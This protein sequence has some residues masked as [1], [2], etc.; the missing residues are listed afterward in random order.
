MKALLR[1][2]SWW[3]C[4]G[5]ASACLGGATGCDTVALVSFQEREFSGVESPGFTSTSGSCNA[6][7]NGEATL[8][9]VLLAD[10]QTPIQPGQVVSN[11]T[12]DA[13]TADQVEFSDSALFEL[14]DVPCSAGECRLAEMTCSTAPGIAEEAGVNRCLRDTS[15]ALAGPIQ[16]ESDTTKAQLFGVMYENAGSLEGWLPADVGDKY[17]D[18]DGDGTA[19]GQQDPGVVRARASD[20]EG[21]RKAALTI[22]GTNWVTAMQNAL[23]ENRTTQ[24]GLWE[25]SGQSTQE[26]I[27]LVSKVHPSE[28]VW[29]AGAGIVESARESTNFS[30]VSGTRANVYQAILHVLD[31]AY[32]PSEFTGHEKTLV[33]FVDGPDDLRLPQF[34]PQAVIQRATDL[35]VRIFIVHLDAAQEPTTQGGTPVHRDDPE[36][37][38][39]RVD[40]QPIQEPCD[41]G[42]SCKNFEE[43]RVPVGYSSTPGGAIEIDPMG[44]TYC[45]P[46]RDDNGRIGPIE[47]YS[48]IA[49][50]TDGGYIYVKDAQGLRPR[51]DWLPFTMDGL[52]KADVV[53]DDLAN[54][55]VPSDE[56]YKLQTSMRVTLGGITRSVD[57]SQRGEAA[58][59]DDA[60]D[61]RSVIFN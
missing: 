60:A 44:Q 25:F 15:V 1:G 20:A 11:Q 61:T 51:M 19:E 5:I 49:C 24:F 46:T 55:T 31:T 43:C 52:W 45:M 27:S 16:F 23:R 42:S 12:V 59:T 33:V 37:W 3:L 14:P 29:A 17:P 39:N 2:R 7:E 58:P 32:A 40:G 38:S 13:L 28:Q 41:D 35:A 9:F 4:A 18:W 21:R 56:S 53:V 36:Y 57:F 26:V 10:D 30:R 8:R 6:I 22:L 34:S 54:R 47:E 50:A 48:R